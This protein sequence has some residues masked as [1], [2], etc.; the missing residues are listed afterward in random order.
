M[1]R[2]P[3]SL[4]P[5]KN[6]VY[7]QNMALKNL[8]A[9]WLLAG[10]FIMAGCSSLRSKPSSDSSSSVQMRDVPYAARGEDQAPRNRILILPFLDQSATRSKDVA[11]AA[12]RMLVREILRTHEF[13]VVSLDDFPQTPSNFVTP[14]KE[15]DMAA[16]TRVAAN[17]GVAAVVEGKILDIQAK[18]NGDSLGLIRR[19]TAQVTTKV[20]I[21]AFA[22][23]NGKEIFSDTR[24]ASSEASSTHVLEAGG[25]DQW[26]SEDPQL[27]SESTRKAFMGALPGLVK[28][29]EK[30][31]W[32]G[33]VAMVSGDRIYINAGRLSGLQIGDILKVT[34]EGDDVYDPE[35]GRF[36]GTAPGRLKGTI[37]VISYFGKDGCVAV[38]HSGSGIQEND[39]VQ[40]Y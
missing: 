12:R 1:D 9:G 23:R 8:H 16:V 30:L 7:T 33:R 28:A 35:S 17:M 20:R 14:E 22:G 37:E 40:L 26:V 3:G 15:Y 36:I 39:R 13:V 32:E 11:A 31:G 6:L 27:V 29:V 5:W 34:E 2:G 24:S 25:A 18:K 19:Y 21:R 4:W 10:L 38:I